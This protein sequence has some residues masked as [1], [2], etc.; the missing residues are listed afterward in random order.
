MPK[1][2]KHASR[3]PSDFKTSG[4]CSTLNNKIN[5]PKHLQTDQLLKRKSTF[6]KPMVY[7]VCMSLGLYLTTNN[8]EI[9][10]G[11]HKHQYIIRDLKLEHEQREEERLTTGA[12][13]FLVSMATPEATNRSKKLLPST[14]RTIGHQPVITPWLS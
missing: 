3:L 11:K 2:A 13:R 6:A 8:N 14:A 9:W 7:Y 5:Q 12:A 4:A 1:L 10:L